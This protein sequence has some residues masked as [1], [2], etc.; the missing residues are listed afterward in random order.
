[1]S[2]FVSSLLTFAV[3]AAGLALADDK[4]AAVPDWSKFVTHAT[5]QGEVTKVDADGFSILLTTPGGQAKGRRQDVRLTYAEAGLVRWKSM[6]PKVDE[7]GKKVA[8]TDKERQRLREPKGAPGYAAER[9][10]LKPGHLVEVTMVRPKDIPAAKAVLQDLQVKHAVIVGTSP[11][12]VL[13][14]DPK[15]KGDEKKKDEKK[16]DK[17]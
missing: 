2:R 1:M 15:K 9:S 3:L 5:Y 12:A 6:P 8:Y 17:T 4:K 10:D 7:R 13:P 16:K 14:V 11:A